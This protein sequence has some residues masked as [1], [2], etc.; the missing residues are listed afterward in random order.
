M[1]TNS[2]NTSVPATA[3]AINPPRW[4]GRKSAVAA[5]RAVIHHPVSR[6]TNG[7]KDF[8]ALPTCG[9]VRPR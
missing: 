6:M 1:T 4:P 5:V 8:S 9:G 2:V 3:P 7:V